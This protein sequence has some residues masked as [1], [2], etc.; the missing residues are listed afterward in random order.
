MRY[1]WQGICFIPSTNY[2]QLSLYMRLAPGFTTGKIS[3]ARNYQMASRNTAYSADIPVVSSPEPHLVRQED[4]K[5]TCSKIGTPPPLAETLHA[6][7]QFRETGHGLERPLVGLNPDT[8]IISHHLPRAESRAPL[9]LYRM[10][11]SRLSQ[12]HIF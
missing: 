9:Q 1:Q 10:I 4:G 3:P 12:A 5:P 11:W 8:N 6:C 2:I 7:L